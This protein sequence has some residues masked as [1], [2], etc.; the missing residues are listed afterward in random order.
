[1]CILLGIRASDC[2]PVRDTGGIFIPG[3]AG[4]GTAQPTHTIPSQDISSKFSKATR[5]S[6]FPLHPYPSDGIIL[7][8]PAG[9]PSSYDP[10]I[11]ADIC[12]AISTSTKGLRAICDSE[13]RFPDVVTF[14]R[15]MIHHEELRKLYARAKEEQLRI[16]AEEIVPIADEDRICEKVT[17]KADGSREVVILDAVDRSRLMIDSRKWLLSKLA[18]KVYGDKI[19]QTL[20]GPDGGAIEIKS[21][22]EMTEEEIDARLHELARR[23]GMPPAL[24]AGDPQG[25]P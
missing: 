20:S 23:R 2:V 18:P 24:Q 25:T 14:Y 8:M 9:R 5:A 16:L 3:S 15:W 19:A 22:R 1:M 11:A 12:A 6:S 21:V 7:Y 17:I 10:T 13:D 4:R